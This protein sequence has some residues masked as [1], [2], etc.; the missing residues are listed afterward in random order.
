MYAQ[1]YD[2]TM[3]RGDADWN[4]VTVDDQWYNGIFAYTRNRQINFCPD[5]KDS[6]PGYGM[7][8][9]AS[10]AAVGAFWDPATKIL[11]ADAPPECIQGN[12]TISLVG[13][14]WCNDSSNDL[15]AAP[16]DNSFKGNNLPQRHNDGLVFGY[17]D[18]HAKW[19]REEQL[20][21]LVFWNPVTA[22]E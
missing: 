9:R 7:N 5:R 10:G 22:T 16:Y 17:A 8:F 1:D 2:E 12:G 4:I 11:I 13:R 6:G 18:G 19:G 20:D 21:T 15:C 3:P 14:W